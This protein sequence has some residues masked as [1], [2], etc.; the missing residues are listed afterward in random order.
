MIEIQG[1]IKRIYNYGQ[2]PVIEITEKELWS[3][4]LNEDISIIEIANRR[5]TIEELIIIPGGEKR[6]INFNGK[7]LLP[8]SQEEWNAGDYYDLYVEPGRIHA[9]RL[10]IIKVN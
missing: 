4:G 9:K 8:I 1:V 5:D 7:Y 6:L 10:P 2:L 3:T